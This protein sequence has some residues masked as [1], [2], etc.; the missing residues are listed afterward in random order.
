MGIRGDKMKKFLS[1]L[2]LGAILS[3]TIIGEVQKVDEDRPDYTED[4]EWSYDEVTQEELYE[5]ALKSV[6]DYLEEH[7]IDIKAMMYKAAILNEQDRSEEAIMLIN[8]VL[9]LDLDNDVALNNRGMYY[10]ELGLFRFGVEDI[11]AAIGIS[12]GTSQE[13]ANKGNALLGLE[14]NEEASEA[15]TMGLEI[16]PDNIFCLYGQGMIYK[17]K[18]KYEEAYELFGKAFMLNPEDDYYYYGVIHIG[19]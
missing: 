9:T 14:R 2:F 10:N 12:G 19:Y 18:E 6:E 7:P 11:E 1:G 16:E 3:A 4:Y 5:D 13:Y 15:Y 8:E 17:N